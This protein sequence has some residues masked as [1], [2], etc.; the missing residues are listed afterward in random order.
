MSK[1]NRQKSEQRKRQTGTTPVARIIS[2]RQV[3]RTPGQVNRRPPQQ[4]VVNQ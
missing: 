4:P 3:H 1:F 2:Q